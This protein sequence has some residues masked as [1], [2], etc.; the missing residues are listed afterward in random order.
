MRHVLTLARNLVRI[1]PVINT[2]KPAR[3]LRLLHFQLSDSSFHVTRVEPQHMSSQPKKLCTE[4]MTVKTIGTHNGTF[5]CDEV[6][7]CFFLRQ[8][9][10]YK[11]GSVME[12]YKGMIGTHFVRVLFKSWL[13]CFL[14]FWF[15]ITRSEL[16]IFLETVIAAFLEQFLIYSLVRDPMSL[17]FQ[18]GVLLYTEIQ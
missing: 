18:M 12:G 11:V 8:L 10:E 2:K 3:V 6:L 7:A 1:N 14:K 16:S 13:C 15:P 5:H 17:T 4:N 9:P